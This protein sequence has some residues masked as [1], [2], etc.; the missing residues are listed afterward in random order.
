MRVLSRA[1]RIVETR[2]CPLKRSAVESQIDIWT[3]TYINAVGLVGERTCFPTTV[4]R[5]VGKRTSPL[6]VVSLKAKSVAHHFGLS[7]FARNTNTAGVSSPSFFLSFWKWIQSTR[8]FCSLSTRVW[9]LRICVMRVFLFVVF[10]LSAVDRRLVLLNST[11]VPSL[12][13]PLV[14]TYGS[15][16]RGKRNVDLSII[17][18]Y[19]L[20]RAQINVGWNRSRARNARV[21]I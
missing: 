10:S 9:S 7:V 4:I 8:S 3:L 16:A 19:E 20:L 11:S 14:L 18:T 12:P 17:L 6:I 15:T 21:K 2:I 5:V 13:D 1:R